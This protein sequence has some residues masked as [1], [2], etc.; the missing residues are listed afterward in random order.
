MKEYKRLT[1]RTKSVIDGTDLIGY[2]EQLLPFH[3]KENVIL[4]RLAELEDKIE[5][6]T[7]IELKKPYIVQNEQSGCYEVWWQEVV[8]RFDWRLTEAESE[9]KLKELKGEKE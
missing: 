8:T 9:A 5:N 6:G 1:F 4:E 7:L 3:D 2:T